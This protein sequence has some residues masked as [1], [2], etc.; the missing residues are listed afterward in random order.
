MTSFDHDILSYKVIMKPFVWECYG[1]AYLLYHYTD[2]LDKDTPTFLY[3]F[4]Y[5]EI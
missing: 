2:K 4:M 1:G 3:I 5:I